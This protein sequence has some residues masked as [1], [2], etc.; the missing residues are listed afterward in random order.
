MVAY[1]SNRNRYVIARRAKPDAA[2]SR[3]DLNNFG[4]QRNEKDAK[5]PTIHRLLPQNQRTAGRFQ[6]PLPSE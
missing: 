4:T 6:R 5:A 2:I 3:Y 1:L